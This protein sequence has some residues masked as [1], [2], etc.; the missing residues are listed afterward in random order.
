MKLN[1]VQ[2]FTAVRTAANLPGVSVVSMSFGGPENMSQLTD[3]SSTFTTPTGHPNVTFVASTGDTQAEHIPGAGEYPAFSPNV[4]AV[5]G[6]TLSLNPDNSYKSEVGWNQHDPA[7]PKSD[8]ISEG[9][10]STVEPLPVY[11]QGVQPFGATNV[12]QTRM[13]PDVSFLAGTDSANPGRATNSNPATGTGV[14]IYDSLGNGPATPWSQA[15][16]DSIGATCWAALIATADQLRQSVNEAPLSSSQT[17]QM[18]YSLPASDFHDVPA[19]TDVI[20]A[21]GPGF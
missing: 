11:Q 16:G 5:G 9:G 4:V 7:N 13:I 20:T 10:F 15:A 21:N 18:I 12:N 8:A 6:T 2:L 19:G 1:P 14:A 3:D 17:L